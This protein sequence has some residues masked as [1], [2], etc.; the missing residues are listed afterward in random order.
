MAEKTKGL[1]SIDAPAD[2]VMDVIAD[3]ERYP[4][5]VAAAKSVEVTA[6]GQGGRADR[7]RFV[8]DAGMVK[9]TYELQYSWA[10]DGMAVSWELISGE[11]QKSQFG[12]YT[13]EPGPN[14]HVGHLRVDGRP[15]DSDDR[16][17]QAEGREDHHRHSS[18]RTEEASRGLSAGATIA[19]PTVRR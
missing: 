11:I 9:D 7:V 4:E 16:S 1:I 18:E 13:L 19:R 3:F 17:L 15:D 5:W 2:A 12:S 10:P 14:D 6:P 8:L